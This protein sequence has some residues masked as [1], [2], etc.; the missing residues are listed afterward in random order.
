[1]ATDAYSVTD[2][3]GTSAESHGL[4]GRVTRYE[5]VNVDGAG[6]VSFRHDDTVAVLDAEGC[7]V[8]PAAAGAFVVLDGSWSAGPTLS[9]IAS[10]DT[11]VHI[12]KL[13]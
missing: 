8:L 1:M 6:R 12:R 11:V 13:A 4:T 5:V 7:N 2:S 10:A 3:I 9:L